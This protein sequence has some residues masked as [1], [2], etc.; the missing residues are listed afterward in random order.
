MRCTLFFV[1]ALIA[2]ALPMA[3]A[4]QPAALTSDGRV[5]RANETDKLVPWNVDRLRF[6]RPDYPYLARVHHRGGKGWFR[7]ELR[8]DGSVAT[9]RVMQTTGGADLDEAAIEAFSRW[10]FKPG[11][12]KWVDEY[13]EFRMYKPDRGIQ[14]P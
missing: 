14:R 4:Y 5:A 8:S 7:L 12:W 2:I 13:V 9:V 3:W 11:K 10:R 6:E 1:A